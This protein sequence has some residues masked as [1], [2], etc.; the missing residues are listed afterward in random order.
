MENYGTFSLGANYWLVMSEGRRPKPPATLGGLRST[1]KTI[2]SV[3]DICT[4]AGPFGGRL[5]LLPGRSID[6]EI[7]LGNDQAI[8]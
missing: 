3:F 5:L 1:K 6:L 4:K 8:L 7:S 2:P